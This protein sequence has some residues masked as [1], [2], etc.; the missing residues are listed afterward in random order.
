M[1]DPEWFIVKRKEEEIIEEPV[2]ILLAEDSPFFQNLI[3]NYLTQAGF[4]VDVAENGKV[5]LEK[6]MQNPEQY[7]MLI[8]DIEMPVMDGF[9]L[10]AEV[11]KNPQFVN[12]PILVQTS[13]AGED[14]K[15]K[16]M[17]L[18]A[19]AYQVKLDREKVLTT[20]NE[21]LETRKQRISHA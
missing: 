14:I 8:T 15:K 11:R 7:S 5:A 4:E 2:R 19:N 16:V 18:G 21:L 1:F 12:L 10:I 9:T 6:L 17:E 13:L 20:I 3:K